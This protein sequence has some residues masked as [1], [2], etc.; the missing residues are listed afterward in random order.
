MSIVSAIPILSFLALF[1]L[2]ALL[3][4]NPESPR[5]DFCKN[6][7]RKQDAIAIVIGA[8]WSGLVYWSLH[9]HNQSR[10]PWM[11]RSAWHAIVAVLMFV[12]VSGVT[13]SYLGRG[14]RFLVPT[15]LAIQAITVLAI[16][17]PNYGFDHQSSWGLDFGHLLA[18]GSF[19]TLAAA[20]GLLAALAN[21][22]T[23]AARFQVAWTAVSVL[24]T[25]GIM[26]SK[27]L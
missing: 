16:V 26:V 4:W 1:I 11:D 6:S 12:S 17:V 5:T 2:S 15:A 3:I 27:E 18:V 22:W 13:A 20:F 21:R 7:F 24:L 19:Y 8:A 23:A 25:L 10:A 9:L 14:S